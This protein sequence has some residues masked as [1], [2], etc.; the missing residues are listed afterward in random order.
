MRKLDDALFVFLITR[1]EVQVDEQG[2]LLGEI[3]SDRRTHA[4][5]ITYK[6]SVGQAGSGERFVKTIGIRPNFVSRSFFEMVCEEFF[7]SPLL[8]GEMTL[9]NTS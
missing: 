4:D 1:A 5:A 2:C 3:S 6:I 8:A 7:V 9:K